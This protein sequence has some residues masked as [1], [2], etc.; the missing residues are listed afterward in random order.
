MNKRKIFGSRMEVFLG[1]AMILGFL[2]PHTSSALMLVNPILCV[3]FIL[4]N[5]ID[6]CRYGIVPIVAIL[7]SMLLNM[8]EATSGKS[9]IMAIFIVMCIMSFPVA[10]EVKIKNTYIYLCFGAIF[11]SQV[12]YMFHIDFISSL[13]DTYYPISWEEDLITRTNESV[14]MSNYLE[15]RQGG[16]YRN[17][18]QM[19]RYVTFLLAIYLVNNTKSSIKKQAWFIALC[20]FSIV[21]T[22]SRSGFIISSIIIFLAL[23][24]NQRSSKNKRIIITLAV[25]VLILY[26]F[27]SGV[28]RSTT[29]EEGLQ[30]SLGA[31]FWLVMDYLS[32]ESSVIYYL[33][34]HLDHTLFTGS[35]ETNY[36]FDCEYGYVIYCFGFIGFFALIYYL[37]KLY[38]HVDKSQRLFFVVCLWMI[39]ST[40]IMS[41]R[42]VFVFMLLLSTIYNRKVIVTDSSIQKK[43]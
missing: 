15:F 10:H 21:L 36:S 26:Y 23:F 39:S 11:F 13:I 31:K 40:I 30:D 17:P 3:I 20:F 1:I 6:F 22:G 25:I 7:F 38:K 18:N 41:Y 8:V 42:A 29:I 24:R 12:A 14:S 35:Y 16:L 4:L 34:G 37:Y 33:F 28:G 27:L 32:H 5:R 19:A 43:N 9:I 2:I